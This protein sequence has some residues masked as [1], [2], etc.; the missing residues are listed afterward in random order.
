MV[1][2]LSTKTTISLDGIYGKF[3]QRFKEDVI[4][5]LYIFFQKAKENGQFQTHSVW[6]IFQFS[7]VAQ[8]CPTLCNSMDH[9]M[10]GFL[11][12]HQLPELSQAH[13]HRVSD[14][15]QPSHPLSSLSPFAF[16]PSQQ[17]GF[18][19][20]SVLHIRWPKYWSFS[21]NISPSNGIFRT[22]FL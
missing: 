12:L 2:N 4:P 7:S 19:K 15:I 13:I 17:Q 21:F 1:K 8:S 5:S 6:P 10:L 9:S 20:E 22:D 18:S 16:N 14:T 3:Y 11:V